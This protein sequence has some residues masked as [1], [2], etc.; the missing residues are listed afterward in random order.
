M[1]KHSN[2][3]QCRNEY[4]KVLSYKTNHI[5]EENLGAQCNIIKPVNEF[6]KRPVK[7]NWASIILYVVSK[8]K[9]I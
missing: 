5:C 2:C 8:R 7:I 1:G 3:K 9:S 6:Y 4:R